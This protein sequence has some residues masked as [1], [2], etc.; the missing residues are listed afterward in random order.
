VKK[1]HSYKKNTRNRPRSELEEGAGKKTLLG[2]GGRSKSKAGLKNAEQQK[3]NKG[4][5][6]KGNRQK[7]GGRTSSIELDKKKKELLEERKR[8]PE[9][10]RVTNFGRDWGNSLKKGLS[11]TPLGRKRRKAWAPENL[12]KNT[13]DRGKK[14]LLQKRS[15]GKKKKKPGRPVWP[16]RES[17]W[18]KKQEEVSSSIPSGA[19]A[20]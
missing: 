19:K 8:R 18:G 2:F 5:C 13:K 10:K 15:Q 4:L 3:N 17:E 14:T 9:S 1:I 12:S 11:G 6:E 20:L 7:R 16:L